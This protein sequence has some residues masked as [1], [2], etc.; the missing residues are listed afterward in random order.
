M[1]LRLYNEAKAT[2][3]V[4]LINDE[5]SEYSES[6][7]LVLMGRDGN[8]IENTQILCVIE[9]DEASPSVLVEFDV[10]SEIETRGKTG[11]AKSQCFQGVSDFLSHSET[12]GRGFKL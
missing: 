12:V 5:D 8:A 6:F 2:L 10:P 11:V 7:M 3:T 1:L 4:E 9:D